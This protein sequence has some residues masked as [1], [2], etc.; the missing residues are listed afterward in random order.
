MI[1]RVQLSVTPKLFTLA[2]LVLLLLSTFVSPPAAQAAPMSGGKCSGM[3][4]AP[5]IGVSPGASIGAASDADLDRELTLM[6]NAGVF[7]VRVDIDWSAIESVRG[8]FNWTNTDRILSAIVGHGLCPLGIIAYTPQW[9]RVAGASNDSHS[10]P[11]N[12]DAFAAFASTVVQRYR[13]YMNLWEVWNEPNIVGFFKP[14]PD[15]TQYSI[16]L[17]AAY[18]AIKAA[19]PEAT[20]LSGGLAPAESNGVNINP[21]AFLQAMY[22]VGGNRYFDAF[23]IHPY[24]YPYLPNDPST[25]S[26]STAQAMWPM[27]D[28]MVAGGDSAKQI[29]LT[30]FGAPTGTASNAVTEQVQSDTIGIVM[31]AVLGNSWMGP[32]FVYASRD[33]GTN[34][35]DPEQNFGLLRRDFTPKL[36]YDRVASFTAGHPA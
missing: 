35:S 23:N 32:A 29:W 5:R 11:A 1:Q 16:L 28:I 33:A 36:A 34:A 9:A 18:T 27:R 19:Q 3:S 24:T 21:K 8:R 31:D 13:D 26:W 17:R 10:R 30:E 25:A 2:T 12:P 6:S 20:V 22:D 4:S 7:G 15:P 14:A